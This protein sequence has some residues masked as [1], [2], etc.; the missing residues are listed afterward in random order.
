MFKLIF[1][2]GR[3]DRNKLIFA[4]GRCDRNKPAND[5][6]NP[7]RTALNRA[8][9]RQL[10]AER[11]ALKG[12]LENIPVGEALDRSSFLSRVADV[13]R[14]IAGG[15]GET[16]EPARARLTF[17]G[18]PVIGSHCIFAKFGMEATQAFTDVVS[19]TV[20]AMSGP[21][22]SSGPI[23]NREQSQLLITSTVVGSFGFELE[24]HREG[25]LQ[26][27]DESA[28]AIALAQTYA[29]L[30]GSVGSE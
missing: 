29:L 22:A 28:V 27:E 24:E 9:Y 3:C 5:D 10:L 7:E 12:I 11:S 1:A 15:E 4:G 23:P 14:R 20:A 8:K 19:L 30:Q 6:S 2:G 13:E 26:L 18:R 16:R 25:H 21:L 17:R